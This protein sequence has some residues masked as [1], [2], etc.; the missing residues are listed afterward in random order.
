MAWVVVAALLAGLAPGHPAGAADDRDLTPNQLT[1]DGTLTREEALA[2]CGPAAAVAFSRARGREVT[3][4]QAV[5]VARGV[6]WT[7]E[8]GMAGP[9]SQVALL[10]RL[11]VQA[12]L[13][14]GIDRAKIAREVTAGRPVIV[15]LVGGAGHYLVAERYDPQARR[16]DFGQGTAVL[17]AAGG[18]RWFGL[19][20]LAS[21]G[22]GTPANAIYLADLSGGR[23]EPQATARAG[24]PSIAAASRLRVN[25]TGGDGLNLR[26]APSM[27]AVRLKVILEGAGLDALGPTR[28]AAGR[29]WRQVR[30]P[31]DSTSG[32]VDAAFLAPAR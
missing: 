13:E 30:D 27:A 16:Y 20:E 14:A 7:A 18:R 31:L 11:G 23:P 1:A 29:S 2:A 28:E 4:A 5:A 25:G 3:L 9:A 15:H 10:K 22:V 12:T 8:R 32:W 17:K 21:L 6:G 24:P 26:A 19:D